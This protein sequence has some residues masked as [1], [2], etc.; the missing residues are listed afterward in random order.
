MS[1]RPGRQFGRLTVV[2]EIAPEK[3]LVDCKCGNELI[4]WRSLLVHKVQRHCDICV[5]LPRG[6]ASNRW[7]HTRRVKTRDGRVRL[8]GTGEWYS[9]SNM[10]ARCQLKTHHAW[11][12]Y[13]GRGIRVCEWWRLPKWQ[14]FKNFLDSMGP[15]PAGMT[16]ER[17]NFNGHYCPDNCKWAGW[18]E[19][20]NNTRRVW[21]ANGW[22]Q[23]PKEAIRE[24]EAR[25]AAE[26]AGIERFV[27]DN[28]NP[29]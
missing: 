8:Y 28:A 19:Q 29:F 22:K 15:R 25:V 7:G 24:M 2:R 26:C 13:G 6:P 10:V 27:E 14:G 3:F 23:P 21:R 11:E 1:L 9:Y 4:V 20:A 18:T 5:P 16:L 17:K 12:D